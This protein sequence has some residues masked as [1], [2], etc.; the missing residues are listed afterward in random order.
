M[1]DCELIKEIKINQKIIESRRKVL[2]NIIKHFYIGNFPSNVYDKRVLIEK[3]KIKN[4][5]R[6]IS[7][8]RWQLFWNKI[9]KYF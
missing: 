3:Q 4:C 6:K 2:N 8:Y 7:Q 5:K 1:K 9:N